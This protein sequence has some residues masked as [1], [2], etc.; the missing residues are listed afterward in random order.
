M[1][2]ESRT[3][4]GLADGLDG[5]QGVAGGLADDIPQLLLPD[6]FSPRSLA[7]IPQPELLGEEKVDGVACFKIISRGRHTKTLWIGCDDHLTIKYTD[8]NAKGLPE[9]VFR[10]GQ[11]G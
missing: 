4:T 3:A 6:L 2:G 7:D 8:E 5:A 11:H 9:V 1:A 10:S